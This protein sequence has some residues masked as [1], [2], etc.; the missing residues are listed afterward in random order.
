ME[1]SDADGEYLFPDI[2]NVVGPNIHLLN[3]YRL[4]ILKQGGGYDLRGAFI[5][6]DIVKDLAIRSKIV[7]NAAPSS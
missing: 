2:H 3:S 7:R 6:D 5:M 1:S 4:A